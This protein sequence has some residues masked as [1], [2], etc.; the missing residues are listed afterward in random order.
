MYAFD[1]Y[2]CLF[3]PLTK[4]EPKMEF[5]SSGL[6]APLLIESSYWLIFFFRDR[7]SYCTWS[8]TIWLTRELRDP[9][10]PPLSAEVTGMAATHN[11]NMGAEYPNSGPHV[12]EQTLY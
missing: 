2:I 4:W 12:C 10:P 6:A 9:L 5:R 7:V 1:M 3:P 8:S 11:F